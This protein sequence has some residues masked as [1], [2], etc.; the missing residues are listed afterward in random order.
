MISLEQA[1]QQENHYTCAPGV[2]RVMANI[3][4]TAFVGPTAVGKNY[5]MERCGYPRVGTLTTRGQRPDDPDDYRYIPLAVM[6]AKIEARQVVQYGASTHTGRI[7]ASEIQDYDP[8]KPNVMDVFSSSMDTLQHQAGY[9]ELKS[10]SVVTQVETWEEW[11]K[12]RFESADGETI[13]GRLDEAE[14]SLQWIIDRGSDPF[15]LTVINAAADP[16]Q[17]LKAIDSYIRTGETDPA[18]QSIALEAAKD[19]Q[20]A[21][22]RLRETFTAAEES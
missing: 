5:L 2:R 12:A 15:R 20:A 1:A 4:M 18:A 14:E 16:S 17:A 13:L 3:A 8:T 6:L 9:G 11:L 10:V 19:M 21:I 22:P 7:Y